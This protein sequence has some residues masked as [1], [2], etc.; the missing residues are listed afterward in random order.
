[1]FLLGILLVLNTAIA[2]SLRGISEQDTAEV[3]SI[4][5]SMTLEEKIGQIFIVGFNGTRPNDD[6]QRLIEEYHIGG[7]IL[8]ER[9]IQYQR[10]VCEKTRYP[11]P[12]DEHPPR[13]LAELT[14]SLQELASHTRS[15]IPLFIAADQE[16]GKGLVIEKGI[17]LFPGNMSLGQTRGAP[18]AYAAGKVTA[19][20]LRAMGV[21]MNLAPV[22]DVHTNINND[23]IGS[24][25][26]GGNPVIVARLG[27]QFMKG[28]HDGGTI[29]VGKHFPGHGDTED[30]PHD[31][32]PKIEYEIAHIEKFMLPPFEV[33]ID[34]GVKAIMTAH[35]E[36]PALRTQE[37]VPIT[38]SEDVIA[39]QL[40]TKMGFKG[41]IITDDLTAMGA[42]TNT[43]SVRQASKLAIDAGNDIVILAHFSPHSSFTMSSFEN[44]FAYLLNQYAA[45]HTN[46]DQSVKRIL[47]LKKAITH[48][49][50]ANLWEVPLEQLEHRLRKVENLDLAQEIADSSIVLLTQS[51]RT[52]SDIGASEF[53]GK[54]A[55]LKELSVDASILLVSSVYYPPDFLYEA[56]QSEGIHK[57][58]ENIKLIY[59]YKPDDRNRGRV[60]WGEEIP[61]WYQDRQLRVMNEDAI[62][63]K[64]QEIIEKATEKNLI[65]FSVARKE[66]VAILRRVSN[67]LSD[68]KIIVV[69]ISEPYIVDE[70]ILRRK[71]ILC[72]ATASGVE[73]SFRAVT[74]ALYGELQPKPIGYVSVSIANRVDREANIGAT[75]WPSVRDGDGCFKKI[76]EW[77]FIVLLCVVASIIGAAVK[78]LSTRKIETWWF[79]RKE[80]GTLCL[81]FG[82][83]LIISTIWGIAAFLLALAAMEIFSE[84]RYVVGIKG[85]PGYNLW[86]AGLTG[87]IGAFLGSSILK[88]IPG[89]KKCL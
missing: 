5:R 25:S 4:V 52:V 42:I 33:L 77:F 39:E 16:N 78:I 74:K 64:S 27:T 84:F 10:P 81:G 31:T 56:L 7:V 22:V 50:D 40:R 69:C 59:R 76:S 34:S 12:A 87:F 54:R 79:V 14:N 82:I 83:Q 24:R 51:G 44:L 70:D 28:L 1:M 17:T 29:A 63:Q 35:M 88:V 53:S 75:I 11:R 15:R 57:D 55:P 86:V 60:I 72:L 43:W 38:L 65:I 46:I 18:L 89:L 9:N 32:L 3:D 36:V 23:I 13:H 68:K 62:D 47:L 26:F 85:L 71:N 45:N 61:R 37:G 20:E 58:I 49:L 41:V 80:D 2:E 6:I 8:F 19:E 67:A 30:D 48:S 66:H 21:N 73:P